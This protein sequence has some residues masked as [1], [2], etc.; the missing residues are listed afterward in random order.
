M[1]SVRHLVQTRGKVAVEL[2]L[3][4]STADGRNLAS[5]VSAKFH[6]EEV[7]YMAHQARTLSVVNDGQVP[8]QFEF[9]RKPNEA[10]YC[11]PWLT[12]NP[13]KGFIAQGEPRFVS[14]ASTVVE[15][16]PARSFCGR[17]S[18]LKS[19]IAAAS[20]TSAMDDIVRN[21]RKSC[22]KSCFLSNAENW[23][24]A[25]RAASFSPRL[26]AAPPLAPPLTMTE[27]S[28]H[29]QA[30]PWTSTLRFS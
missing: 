23:G 19:D 8:C 13:P 25:R 10:T 27:L 14:P 3:C 9:I 7:K 11:K 2:K 1:H 4:F 28:L 24:R 17:T 16:E 5:F 26:A 30:L 12:A 22:P 15:L 29:P 18:A 6:F 20:K 21:E